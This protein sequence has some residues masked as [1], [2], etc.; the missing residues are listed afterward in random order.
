M[1]EIYTDGASSPQTTQAAGW[2]FAISPLNPGNPWVVYHGYLPPPSTNNIAE[3]L[4]VLNALKFLW[5][6]SNEGK[7]FIPPAII[8]SDSQY[9]VKSMLEWRAKWEYQGMPD[10]N[11]ELLK[12]LF[13][14]HDRVKSICDLTVKWV[15]GHAGHVGNEIADK[16]SVHAKNDS[17]LVVT[18][19]IVRSNKVIG[20]FDDYIGL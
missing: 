10:K 6:F 17:Q 7:K 4:G 3:L 2:A 9:V 20:S 13:I 5:R 18:N 15:K 19:N 11:V 12:E 8:F 1:I 14:Y 16:W